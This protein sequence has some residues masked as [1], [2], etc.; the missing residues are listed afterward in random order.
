MVRSVWLCQVDGGLALAGLAHEAYE[1]TLW[2]RALLL[3]RW[4]SVEPLGLTLVQKVAELV[5]MVSP[6]YQDVLELRA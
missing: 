1:W 5:G 6:V 2:Q 4:H 3:P